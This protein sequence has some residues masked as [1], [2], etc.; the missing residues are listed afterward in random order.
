M[1]RHTAMSAGGL[2]GLSALLCWSSALL[3][4]ETWRAVCRWTL[5]VVCGKYA[6]VNDDAKSQLKSWQL[7]AAL[8][9]LIGCLV[10]VIATI[11]DIY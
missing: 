2:C 9:V 11:N 5:P 3:K 8:A 6:G 1:T 10:T 7:W 4:R